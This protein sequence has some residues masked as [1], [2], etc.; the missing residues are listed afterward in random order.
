[1]MTIIS[2]N[3]K[4]NVTQCPQDGIHDFT[5]VNIYILEMTLLYMCVYGVCACVCLYVCVCVALTGTM[6]AKNGL[7]G[8]EKV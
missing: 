7:T 3:G 6:D 2:L 8:H 1:M 4:P 5:G